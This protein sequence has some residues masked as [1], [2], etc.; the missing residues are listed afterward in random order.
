M[1]EK[2]VPATA[3]IDEDHEHNAESAEHVDRLDAVGVLADGR[4]TFQDQLGTAAGH[5]AAQV[6]LEFGLLVEQ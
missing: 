3:V 4:W 5:R 2:V 1:H 6:M